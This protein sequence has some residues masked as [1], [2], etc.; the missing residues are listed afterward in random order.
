MNKILHLLWGE[1]QENVF[2][3]V[4]KSRSRYLFLNLI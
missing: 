1:A 3:D 2:K 4:D